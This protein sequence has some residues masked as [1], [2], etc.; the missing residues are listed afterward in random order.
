MIFDTYFFN[1]LISNAAHRSVSK[2]SVLDPKAK[3]KKLIT[4]H[5]V[6]QLKLVK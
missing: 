4:K 5:L 1:P 2:I 6:K 3:T